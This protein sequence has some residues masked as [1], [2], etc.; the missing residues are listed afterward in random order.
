MNQSIPVNY[1]INELH[2]KETLS[3]RAKNICLDN[4][5]NNLYK[6]LAFYKEHGSF[7]SLRNCGEKSNSELIALAEKYIDDY[8]SLQGM[9]I[10]G[11]QHRTFEECKILCFE[12]FK[13]SSTQ[14]ESFRNAF[15]EDRFPFFQFLLMVIKNLLKEREYFIFEHNFGF[16]E[17]KKK[18]TLQAIGNKFG[19]TRERA[20]Q[21]VMVLLPQIKDFLMPFADELNFIENHL[22]Y[23]L[24]RYKD[25]IRIDNATKEQLNEIEELNCTSRFYCFGFSIL[26]HNNY[27]FFQYALEYYENYY[28]INRKLFEQFNFTKFYNDLKLIMNSVVRKSYSIDFRHY[29]RTFYR[30]GKF[31]YFERI[32][33]VCKQIALNEFELRCNI[34]DE[35]VI[36]R[37]TKIRLHE[38]VEYILAETGRPM[39][40]SEI[41][42]LIR[43][44]KIKEN[45]YLE[46]LR[47]AIISSPEIA[48]IG[49]SSTYALKSWHHVKLGTIKQLAIEYLEG[50]ENPMHISMITKHI[51]QHRN[52][53]EKNIYSN[54]KLD[55]HGN[56][57]FYKGGYIGLSSKDYTAF[58]Q[59]NVQLKLL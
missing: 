57:V 18:H 31:S 34:N 28:L 20:R 40:L 23:E 56:F 22:Q 29:I 51:N 54:L 50:N 16:F 55:Q 1:H 46:S 7:L 30:P 45:I 24:K 42:Q 21:I 13:L 5:M 15:M 11:E 9:F 3:E 59:T 4:D 10:A 38:H 36:P 47:S 43:K 44:R 35:I 49:K 27:S 8:D 58:E 32:V 19:I 39:H 33:E 37:N 26:Y 53:N 17:D 52:T 2:L 6:F 48:T 41:Y 25:Y 12:F 14:A